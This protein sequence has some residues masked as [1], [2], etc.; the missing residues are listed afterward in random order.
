M[1]Y[2]KLKNSTFFFISILILGIICFFYLAELDRNFSHVWSVESFY[3]W[4]VGGGIIGVYNTWIRYV[5]SLDE[6][7]YNK[8]FIFDVNSV[9]QHNHIL[10][11]NFQDI[12]KEA[13]HIYSN[14]DIPSMKDVDSLFSSITIEDKWKVFILKW[15]DDP[16]QN[17]CKNLC[18]NTCRLINQIPEIRCAMFSVLQPHSKIPPH[19]GPFT[20]CLRYHLALSVPK[21]RNN[22]YIRVHGQKYHWKE[23]EDI[24]FDDTYEHEVYN[25]TDE[26]R[27]ILF[28]DVVR[29]LNGIPGKINDILTS[30]GKF[31]SFTKNMNDRGEKLV[32]IKQNE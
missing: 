22:C 11:N 21:D 1:K 2:P 5:S 13:L 27:I 4:Y 16:T 14:Y 17:N 29:P 15:Y 18:P 30:N 23:G 9:F 31:A 10:K 28:V 8:P 19:R 6:R 20:G 32:K 12:K 26:I 3:D 25:N 24:V 7:L